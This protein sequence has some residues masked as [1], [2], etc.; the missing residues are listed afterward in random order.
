M[1]RLKDAQF[2]F[3]RGRAPTRGRRL[4]PLI[5]L[6]LFVSSALM[7]LSR[8]DHS[9]LSDLRWQVASSMSPLFQ[10]AMVPL[11][12]LRDVGRTLGTQAGLQQEVDRLKQE[13]Q[14]LASWEWRA[15]Q[16]ESK[17]ADLEAIA[18]T[19]PAQKLDFITGRVIADSSGGAF[20]C[21]VTIDAGSNNKL[22]VG[23]PVVNA[24]GLLGR[25]VDIGPTSARVLLATDI[26]SRIP[27]V[28]GPTAARAILA[29]DNTSE[30]RLIYLP[31]GAK[32]TQGDDVATSG[33]GGLFPAGLRI[34]VVH[35]GKDTEPRV[36]IRANLDH[37]DYV[38]VL[39]YDDPSSNLTDEP[40][41]Q[42]SATDAARSDA[43]TNSGT[44]PHP[45]SGQ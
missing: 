38:S 39:F 12:P 15:R 42:K 44:S 36:R 9:M 5:L 45:G 29:G 16:L 8:M 10:S 31:D 14:R 17:L 26:N 30:P 35:G 1:T 32:V 20:V 18:R 19:V 23:Y 2:I 33:T 25:I 4:R 37:L 7:L 40:A 11:D 34:G 24:D 43:G 28:V 13:N 41:K 6:L 22:K 27:V 21:N 3:A